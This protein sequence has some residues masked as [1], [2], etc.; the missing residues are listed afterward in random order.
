MA[1][2]GGGQLCRGLLMVGEAGIEP[3]RACAQ[4]ILSPSCIPIPPL[5]RD[6]KGCVAHI[7]IVHMQ[8]M[9]C[10]VEVHDGERGRVELL[11][12]SRLPVRVFFEM[13]FYLLTICRMSI[14]DFVIEKENEIPAT[15]QLQCVGIFF[16]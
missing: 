3:A 9:I 14:K 1:A 7:M 8:C 16:F 2:L 13:I 11:Y 4:R 10:K 6:L 15:F 12:D 5:A